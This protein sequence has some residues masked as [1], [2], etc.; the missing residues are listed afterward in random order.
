MRDQ[1]FEL[2]ESEL[3]ILVQR[4]R[5]AAWEKS[6]HIVLAAIDEA[7]PVRAAD[8]CAAIGTDKAAISRHV[9]HLLEAGLVIASPDPDDGRANLLTTTAAGRSQLAVVRTERR[10]RLQQ[11]LAQWGD[12]ELSSFADR[13]RQYNSDLA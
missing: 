6:G 9:Q 8:L 1:A 10:E 3:R 13:L 4:V 2:L 5:R 7:G 11:R 12:D